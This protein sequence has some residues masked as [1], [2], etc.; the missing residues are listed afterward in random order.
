MTLFGEKIRALRADRGVTMKQMAETLRV[1]SAYLSALEHGHRGK[2]GP[3]LIHQICDYFGLI[4]DDAEEVKNLAHLSH[5][6]VTVDTSGLTPKATEL[7]NL[8]ANTISDLDEPTIQWIIDEITAARI[9][10]KGP[11]H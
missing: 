3:G 8:L 4:W 6:R 2:P 5:P 7:A 10:P 1:S 11:A 9:V